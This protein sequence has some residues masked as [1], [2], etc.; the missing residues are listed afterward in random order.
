MSRIINQGVGGFL[1]PP[2]H[3][4]HTKGVETDLNRRPEDRGGMSLEAAAECNW[5]DAATRGRA[6]ALLAWQP[7]PIDT[8]EI[9]DWIRQ[10]LGYFC[11]CYNFGPDVPENWYAARLTIDANANPLEHCMRHAGVHLIRKYYPHF[12]PT[13]EQFQEAY[14]GKK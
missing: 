6:K 10:V 12:V 7:P 2:G 11:S 3:P 13:A 5:L 14:W 9:Q 4:M 8:P 1:C